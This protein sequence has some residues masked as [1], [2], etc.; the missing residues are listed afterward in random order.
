[1]LAKATKSATMDKL[2]IRADGSLGSSERPTEEIESRFIEGSEAPASI[3]L[4]K[5]MKARGWQE[6]RAPRF[7]S[8]IVRSD[9][10][11]A[12]CSNPVESG[13]NEEDTKSGFRG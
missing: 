10:A 11:Q 6:H 5:I 7:L 9:L 4:E 2:S 12:S 3:F 1:M 8:A 13:H